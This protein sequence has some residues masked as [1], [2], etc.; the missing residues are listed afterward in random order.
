MI[1]YILQVV[2]FQTIFLALYD[3]FLQKETF[4]KWNRLYLLITPL[5]SFVIPLL[6]F[7][8]LKNSVSQEYIE[9]LP[10]VFLNPQVV[11]DQ[12]N[13]NNSSVNYLTIIFYVGALLFT[14]LFLMRLT[15]LLKLITSN[16]VIRKTNYS[17]V[18]LEDKKA[19]FSFFNYIFINE[20]LLKSKD[21][22]IIKHELIHC[23]QKHTIDLLFFELLKIILW[24]NP[25][26]YLYQ[27]RI[28]L[29]HEYISDAE[30]VK[31][32]TKKAYFNRLLSET[33]SV[34]NISFINQ[35]FKHSL[36]KKRIIMITKE[37]SPKMKQ[38]K[39][40]LILPLLT[41]ML[42]YTSCTNDAQAEI[43]EMNALIE[44]E[45]IPNNGKYF[46]GKNGVKIFMGTYLAGEV[47]SF[48]E[49]SDKEKEIFN[50]FRNLENSRVEYNLVIDS[51]GDRVHFLKVPTPPI[52]NTVIEDDGSV[53]FAIIEDVPV[54]PGCE[55]TKEELRICLQEKITQHVNVN[56]N[57]DLA[58]T[59]K[60]TPG[61][62]RI[63]VLFKIDKEGNISEVKARA[64]HQTLADEAI[65]VINL[66]P[67]MKPGKQKGDNVGVKYS[68]PI[69]FKVE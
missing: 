54:F 64:P 61:V 27:K 18:L 69:A 51:N 52:K 41:L 31:E 23:K 17:L 30:V 6:K 16:K 50:E 58:S 42:V 20:K 66:L 13:Q 65:R 24:F 9:Q 34:E 47:V 37:K 35:F 29:L 32:T 2:I 57:S 36:I 10:T 55:G 43:E 11:I 5:L 46:E 19:A 15:K 62:N 1:N 21:L 25:M 7:S 56:F 22:Q 45:V 49:M 44:N 67:K 53:P 38:L 4:F 33:F 14:S 28:T 63:F 39:Y 68:L 59:L 3:L 12:V 48:E 40:L 60:L 8:S 26:V